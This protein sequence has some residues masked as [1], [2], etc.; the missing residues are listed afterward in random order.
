MRS[1]EERLAYARGY[2]M[3]RRSAWPMEIAS[4]IPETAYRDLAVAARELSYSIDSWLAGFDD[5][6]TEPRM[7]EIDAAR[8]RLAEAINATVNV[9]MN[10]EFRS[11]QP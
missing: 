11:P 8:D 4:K 6:D 3:G 1:R 7:L 5:R 9:I 10:R 2:N